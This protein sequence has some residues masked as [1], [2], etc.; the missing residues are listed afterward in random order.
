MKG[1][2]WDANSFNRPIGGWDVS[3]VTN[4]DYMFN[5]AAHFN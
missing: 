5:G 2:F 4:M 1:M 3:N